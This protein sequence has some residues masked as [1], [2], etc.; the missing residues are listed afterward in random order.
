MINTRAP[1]PA[2]SVAYEYLHILSLI[3]IYPRDLNIIIIIIDEQFWSAQPVNPARKV[4]PD[5]ANIVWKTEPT[6]LF[7]IAPLCTV[8]AC[9]IG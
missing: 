8:N 5:Y 6:L 2:E 1:T 3:F 4:L 7:F 9:D